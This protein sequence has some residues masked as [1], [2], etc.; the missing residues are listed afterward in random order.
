MLSS[1]VDVSSLRPPLWT[2]SG[3]CSDPSQT[4]GATSWLTTYFQHE[5]LNVNKTQALFVDDAAI[6]YLNWVIQLKAKV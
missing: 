6:I 1:L 3:P 2:V 4:S 5:H